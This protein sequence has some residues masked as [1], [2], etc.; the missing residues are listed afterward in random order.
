MNVYQHP[1]NHFVAGFIGNPAM[2]F[3][4][5]EISDGAFSANG[6]AYPLKAGANGAANRQLPSGEVTLGFRP[7]NLTTDAAH[8]KI[9][10]VELD[11]VEHMGHETIVY[12]TLAGN[13]LIA[14][15]HSK[16]DAQ[17]LTGFDYRPTEAS[18]VVADLATCRSGDDYGSTEASSAVAGPGRACPRRAFA[19]N[20]LCRTR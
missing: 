13:S 15:L 6:V 2:N 18:S 7:E 5:G 10:D 17:H 11:V 19:H 9:A 4:D 12:F 1:A 16:A 14:R 3:V 8:P 20:Q